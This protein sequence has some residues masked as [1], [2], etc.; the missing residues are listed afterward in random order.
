MLTETCQGGGIPA[1]S[2]VDLR[3]PRDHRAQHDMW[4]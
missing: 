1:E 2:A 3:L 4:F